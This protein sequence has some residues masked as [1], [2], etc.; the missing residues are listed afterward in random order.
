MKQKLDIENWHRKAHFNFFKQ[1]DEP[2]YGVCVTIDCNAAYRFAKQN[3]ISFYLYTLFEAL[4]AT[5]SVEPFRYRIEGDEVFIY[6]EIIAASTIARPNGT[7]GYGYIDYHADMAKFITEASKEVERVQARNDLE[8]SSI[9]NVI[10][11]S[12]L[13][14]VDFTSLSHARTFSIKNSC[15]SISFGKM[16]EKDG[17]R[18]MPM[19]I[20]VHHALVDGLHIGQYVD[21]FQQLMNG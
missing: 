4:N 11:F 9:E 10:R 1:F 18:S 16:T 15:P 12:S 13:P 14:W 6:D 2:M 20:H 5:L 3:K 21:S 8:L 19:S 17:R 7:F